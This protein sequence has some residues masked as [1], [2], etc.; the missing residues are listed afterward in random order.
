MVQWIWTSWNKAFINT[1]PWIDLGF[2]WLMRVSQHVTPVVVIPMMPMTMVV[3][4]D[5]WSEIK[6]GC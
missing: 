2:L 5:K 4:V 1:I 6:S 3:P